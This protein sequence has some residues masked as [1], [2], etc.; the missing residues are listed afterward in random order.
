VFIKF[1]SSTLYILKGFSSVPAPCHWAK[2]PNDEK[3][4]K[5][6]IMDIV[7]FMVASFFD[8]TNVTFFYLKTNVFEKSCK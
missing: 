3:I 8:K 5:K 1:K 4:N 6:V 2:S 7:F